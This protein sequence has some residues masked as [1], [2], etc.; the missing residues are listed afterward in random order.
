MSAVQAR[1]YIIFLLKQRRHEV[2]EV[3]ELNTS[4]RKFLYIINEDFAL[5]NTAKLTKLL[6]GANHVPSM[7]QQHCCGLLFTSP[8]S[9]PV[10]SSVPRRS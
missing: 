2:A 10:N 5:T 8:V 1:N 3:G 9:V 4:E 6:P 7:F